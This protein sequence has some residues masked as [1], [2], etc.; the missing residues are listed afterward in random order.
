M[1]RRIIFTLFVIITI[2][3]YSQNFVHANGK[4]IIDTSGNEI[5]LKGVNI[6][7]WLVPENWM[8]GIYDSTD[9]T[10]RNSLKMLELR[11]TQLEVDNLVDKWQDNWFKQ[12]DLEI[13]SNSGFN[14]IRVPFGWRNLQDRNMN[15]KLDSTGNIDFRRLDWIVNEAKNNNMYVLFDYHYW[16]NQDVAYNVISDVDSVKTHTAILWKEVANHFKDNNAVLGYDLLN[17][18][19]GSWGDHVMDMIYDS[20]RSVDTNHLISIEWTYP[21]TVRWK[22]VM[23]QDHFYALSSSNLAGNQQIF[24]DVYVPI[25]NLHDSLNVPFYVG[26]LHTFNSD[27]TLEWLLSELCLRNIHWSP[28]TYKTVNMWGWGMINTMPINVSVNINTDSYNTILTK[29][30]STGNESNW[31][32]MTNLHQ[33]WSDATDCNSYLSNSNGVTIPEFSVYPN[34]AINKV[35]FSR[36]SNIQLYDCFGN[37]LMIT[38]SPVI[39][40]DIS[41]LNVG[42]YILKDEHSSFKIFKN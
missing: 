21:D 12:E 31:F 27:S 18:P 20:I 6:G 33:I 35:Y 13:I 34:P 19:T 4:L 11:F 41:N 16:L 1:K 14:F 38:N 25:L 10:N 28:W 2:K 8:C 39:E 9:A 37:L 7:G 32:F 22:N 30:E 24:N 42:M 40:I 23:Y 36:Y 29:W 5:L 17:E 26:E 3:S 15:W